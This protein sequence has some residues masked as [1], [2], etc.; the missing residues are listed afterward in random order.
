VYPAKHYSEIDALLFGDKK[1]T[2]KT[3]PKRAAGKIRQ[4]HKKPR[5]A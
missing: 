3:K 2:V 5:A 1:K 4:L